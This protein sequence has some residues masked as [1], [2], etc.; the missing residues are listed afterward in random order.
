MGDEREVQE[1]RKLFIGGLSY[2]TTDDSLREAFGRYG[3]LV[4]GL[5]HPCNFFL[6]TLL[7]CVRENAIVSIM[8]SNTASP[9]PSPLCRLVVA[10]RIFQRI[11]FAPSSSTSA[12]PPH[13]AHTPD[14][15]R[16]MNDR[17]TG[18][19]RGFGFVTFVNSADAQAAKDGL[20]DRV[21]CRPA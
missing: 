19:S 12:S 4:E 1:Q 9:K 2:S 20:S 18:Q 21:R 17:E 8:Q 13:W 16:I 15:A 14:T 6:F 11:D 7:P 3:E 5:L 10:L